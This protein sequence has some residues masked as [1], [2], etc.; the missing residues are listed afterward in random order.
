ES[1]YVILLQGVFFPCKRLMIPEEPSRIRRLTSSRHTQV[2]SITQDG[3]RRSI[4]LKL[5][6]LDSV[7]V[8][9]FNRNL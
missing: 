5:Q 4:T 8:G 7:L 9:D 2:P 3:Q 6:I 1:D